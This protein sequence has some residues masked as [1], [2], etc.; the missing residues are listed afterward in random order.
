VVVQIGKRTK[1]N[2]FYTNVP[3]SIDVINNLVEI[4]DEEERNKASRFMFDKDRYLFITAHSL[5][6]Y[7]LWRITAISN[8]R[9]RI[10]RFGKPELAVPFGESSFRFN[11]S[12]STSLAVCA[13][14]FGYDVG[15]DVERVD[16]GF[17]I[18]DIVA[19]Y[20]TEGERAQ[21]ADRQGPSRVDAFF[22]LWTLK[23]AIIKAIGHGLSMSLHD[24]SFT[25]D[26]FSLVISP[27]CNDATRR[28]HVERRKIGPSHW[29]SLAVRRPAEVAIFADWQLV[30]SAEIV[31]EAHRFVR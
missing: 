8:W 4:L 20:F 10:G 12:H 25:L 28:W 17:E 11:L 1:V 22:Q 24:F 19:A 21:L 2:V 23:E 13:I 16:Y 14:S 15:I 3:A 5:L 18:D 26:P 9:F 6:R 29:V 7:A 27:N 30:T 31:S